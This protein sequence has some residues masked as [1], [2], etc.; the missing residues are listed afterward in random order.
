MTCN[1]RDQIFSQPWLIRSRIIAVHHS[2]KPVGTHHQVA[3]ECISI[4][5][6]TR[7]PG[8]QGV[9]VLGETLME[10]SGRRAVKRIRRVVGGTPLPRALAI[11]ISSLIVVRSLRVVGLVN[12]TQTATAT[13]TGSHAASSAR[14]ARAAFAQ[15]PNNTRPARVWSRQLTQCQ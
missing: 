12:W 13:G 1:L 6:Q 11:L 5:I 10:L 4:S 3:M 2:H 9:Y 15:H 7:L 14:M 8:T